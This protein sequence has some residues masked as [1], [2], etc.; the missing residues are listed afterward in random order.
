MLAASSVDNL[1]NNALVGKKFAEKF[2][3]NFLKLLLV[4]ENFS[5]ISKKFQRNFNEISMKDYSSYK[6]IILTQ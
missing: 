6:R 5:I 3:E 2:A 1:G 4:L